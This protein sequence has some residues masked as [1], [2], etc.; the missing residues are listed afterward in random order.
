MR[1]FGAFCFLVTTVLKFDNLPYYQRI[2]LSET[3]HQKNV[4]SQFLIKKLQ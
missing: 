4:F 3:T 1:K 2:I